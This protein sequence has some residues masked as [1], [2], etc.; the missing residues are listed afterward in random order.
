MRDL[1]GDDFAVKSWKAI[2]P[3]GLLSIGLVLAS[4]ILAQQQ[5]APVPDAPTPQA[6]PP[7]P[8]ISGGGITPGAGSG[9]APTTPDSG[10]GPGAQ[11]AP[12]QPPTPPSQQP[13]AVPQ[14]QP[15]TTP[16]E[17]GTGAVTKFVVQVNFVQ[18]PVTV[19]DSKGNLVSGLT[20]RDFTVYENST[21]EPLRVFSVDPEPLSVAFVIDQTLPSN[22]MDQVN[23]SMGSIEGAL[24]QYDEAAVF[25]YTNGAK[26]WTGF[27]GGQSSRLPAVL[28]LA[29]S[30][31]SDPSVPVTGGNPFSACAISIN[32]NCPDPNLQPGKSTQSIGQ[33]D[34]P[35]EIHTLNDAILAA[36]KELSS[37]PKERRRIIFVIS[38]GKEY[39]SKAT[40]KEVVRY[41]QT[42]HIA[43][44]G[45]LVGDSAHW[46]VEWL[47]R[48]HVPLTGVYDNI[49]YKYTLATGG[50]YY[51][52][53]SVNGIERSYAKIADQARD[54]Y[55]LGYL[56]HE[57]IYDDKFRNIDVR[58]DRPNV[59]VI[60]PLG[61][62]PSAQEYK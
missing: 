31:G 42:N 61:Y 56:S 12:D 4:G 37:R 20:W 24:T 32:G 39:G 14:P 53:G 29:Q 11:T 1:W 15:Q 30:T 33:L 44:Y 34:L 60:A 5:P 35:K 58:V 62:Y 38:D 13:A 22:V 26:E 8:G 45:T 7:L 17:Q 50:D 19:K 49:L 54:Q 27:T 36:A 43:V 3:V 16:P 28:S 57:S 23:R 47:D 55:T 21:R 59:T 18:V 41:L 25:T 51:A 2:A 40:W 52:E 46:G 10:S 6:P 9:E 48:V